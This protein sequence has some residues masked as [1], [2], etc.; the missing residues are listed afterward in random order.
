VATLV[1][2]PRAVLADGPERVVFSYSAPPDCP[3][4]ADFAARVEAMGAHIARASAG[5][6]AR[7]FEVLI[8]RTGAGFSGTLTV[9]APGGGAHVRSVQCGRCESVAQ[10]LA[11]VTAMSLADGPHERE[12][13]QDAGGPRAEAPAAPSPGQERPPD[14]PLTNADG[15]ASG[16]LAV[17]ASW[18]SWTPSGVG[19]MAVASGGTH[20]GV[21]ASL[22][23][24]SLQDAQHPSG[25]QATLGIGQGLAMRLGAVASWGAPWATD[26]A[27]GFVLQAG[28]RASRLQ[29]AKWN[30]STSGQDCESQWSGGG[31][32]FP[33]APDA[34]CRSG[35][36]APTTW[37]S[38]SPYLAGSIVVQIAP[39]APVRPFVGA[40][41]VWSGNDVGD[42]GTY[43]TLDAGLSWRAW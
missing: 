33:S 31:V 17:L 19:V 7:H 35:P 23:S 41:F 3:A 10:A 2:S 8:A 6:R 5:E 37:L 38:L 42:S 16:G 4:E 12:G 15:D 34:E 22:S 32:G 14:P 27:F 9:V 11:L 39:T 20:L 18:N 13:A 26:E 36:G 40:T 21:A 43:L 24:V 30:L 29:G 1:L 28:L 25:Q